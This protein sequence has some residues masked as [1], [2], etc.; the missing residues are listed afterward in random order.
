MPQDEIFVTK[1]IDNRISMRY[2]IIL[3][4]CLYTKDSLIERKDY[5]V[6][7]GNGKLV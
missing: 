5:L 2:N 4:K 3:E 7:F 1:K 6:Y